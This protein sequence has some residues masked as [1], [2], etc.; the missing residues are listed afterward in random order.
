MKNL[1][2]TAALLLIGTA[3]LAQFKGG[4]DGS[5]KKNVI[6]INPIGFLFGNASVG[7]ERAINDNSAIQVNG[8][9]G[10]IS[11]GGV[12]Y[13]NVGFGIDYKYYFAK[14][15]S[16]PLGFY[17]SPGVGFY[18]VKVKE[19]GGTSVSGS[20]FIIKGVIGNQW[21]WDSGFSLDLFGGINF[22]AGGKIKGSG[23]VEYTKYNGVLPALGLGIGYAF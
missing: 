18:S 1:F 8:S 7:F 16:A 4:N 21:I 10:G 3:A 23:G 9:F 12:K 22:Y 13:T 11:L 5:D 20:G 17:A 14:D 19:A 6:K 2:L 15:K